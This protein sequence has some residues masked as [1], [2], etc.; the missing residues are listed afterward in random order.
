MRKIDQEWVRFGLAQEKRG[1]VLCAAPL[2]NFYSRCLRC[3]VLLKEDSELGSSSSLEVAVAALDELGPQ[4]LDELDELEED[5]ELELAE[6]GSVIGS[7]VLV[8]VSSVEVRAS[9]VGCIMCTVRTTVGCV[10]SLVN[11]VSARQRGQEAFDL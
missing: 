2:V 6:S 4:E 7:K 8:L 11:S 5:K 10:R 3:D 9:F 1:C